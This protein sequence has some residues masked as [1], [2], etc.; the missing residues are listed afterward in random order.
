MS[1]PVFDGRPSLKRK[2]GVASCSECYRRKQK[3]DHKNPCNNCLARNVPTK[4]VYD[5]SVPPTQ[6]KEPE[7]PT[8][9]NPAAAN[10]V[11][12][13]ESVERTLQGSVDLGYSLIA[14]SNT[15]VGLQ[16]VNTP[17]DACLQLADRFEILGNE[18]FQTIKATYNDGPRPFRS[19]GDIEALIAKLPPRTDIEALVDFFFREVNWHYSILEILYFDSLFSRWPPTGQMEAVN[20]LQTAELSMELRYFPSLLF[21]VIALALQF[22]PNDRGLLAKSSLTGV[23]SSQTYSDLGDEL[24][25]RLGRPGFALAAVQADFLRSSWLKNFGRGI[26]AWHA[27]GCAI[28]QAQELG[29]HR[30]KEIYQTNQ[31]NLEK[32]LSLFWYEENRK[33]LWINLFVWD[34]FMA[35]ILGRPRMIHLEDC[36]VKPPLDCNIPSEP[37]TAIPMAVRLEE[38]HG[39]STVSA[40]LFRY[41]LACK[42]HKMRATKV[43]RPRPKDYSVVRVLHEE[44]TSLLVELPGFLQADNSDTTWDVEYPYLPQI[45]QELKVMANL[46]LMTL[47]RPHLISNAES[48]KAA[49]QAAL[50]TIDCQQRFFAQAEKHHYHLFGLAFYIVDASFLVSIITILFPPQSQDAKQRI[51]Q[52]LQHV[53]ESLSAMEAFNPIA[54][55]GLYILQRCYHKLKAVRGSPSST[56]E[57]RQ[58]SYV[59]PGDELHDLIRDLGYDDFNSLPNLLPDH[60]QSNTPSS[61]GFS[62]HPP[63]RSETALIRHI[64]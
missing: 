20:Y 55:S 35:M 21:Q 61:L 50:E 36:D 3:C 59:T 14:G 39:I 16:D 47:H 15:F 6:A 4:C 53:I 64:G 34:S 25:S 10:P 54:L 13:Q 40:L 45:R 44:I 23:A 7:L 12:P 56:S 42:M 62:S 48:R 26:E 60:S 57:T 38:S 2:R 30:Q 33:R 41:A 24:L 5:A 43:D 8:A 32:T 46:F 31:I 28:R 27:V 1:R 19:K 49:L 18:E 51:E 22:L 52:N 17:S 9:P 37:S 63:R 29:L 11:N 58:P